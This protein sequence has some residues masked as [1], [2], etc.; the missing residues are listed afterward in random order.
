MTTED[1]P[2]IRVGRTVLRWIGWA[3]VVLE[4]VLLWR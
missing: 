3:L 2:F 4:I 1:V